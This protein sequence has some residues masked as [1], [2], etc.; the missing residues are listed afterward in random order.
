LIATGRSL[1]QETWV[2]SLV[3]QPEGLEAHPM[4]LHMIDREI[5]HVHKFWLIRA[6]LVLLVTCGVDAAVV[7]VAT[8]PLKWAPFITGT[9]PLTMWL[10]VG[11]PVLNEEKR[12]SETR[13]V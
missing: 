12:K 3:K 13:G 10:F 6:I 1:F 4:K 11:I 9:L 5:W 2:F 7:A 8:Q